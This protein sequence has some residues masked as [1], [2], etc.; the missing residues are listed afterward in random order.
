NM[1]L[2]HM[3]NVGAN[4]QT[5]GLSVDG[6]GIK[7]A[8]NNA[9]PSNM[10]AMQLMTLGQGIATNPGGGNQA[11]QTTGTAAAAASPHAADGMWLPGGASGFLSGSA[12][13]GSVAV[14]GGGGR[15]DVR[16]MVI[17]GGLDMPVGDGFTIGAVLAYA[18]AS[19]VLRS[20][21]NS[22]QSDSIQGGVFV[23]YDWGSW[24]AQAFGVYGHQTMTTRR[25]AVV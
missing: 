4:T 9:N 19:A 17:G 23:R 13:Q 1:V 7:A 15:A 14:G 25:I 20:S 16:G 11:V 8:L 12:L 18:D 21:P 3:A 10:Q 5:A 6:D 24:D 22:L 2:Q